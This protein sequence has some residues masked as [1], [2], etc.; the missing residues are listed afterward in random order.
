MCAASHYKKKPKRNNQY[1]WTNSMT[2]VGEITHIAKR[3]AGRLSS[4]LQFLRLSRLTETAKHEADL[5]LFLQPP[6]HQ[7]L[8]SRTGLLHTGVPLAL[9][10][11]PPAWH[12]SLARYLAQSWC[13]RCAPNSSRVYYREERL[14][15][16][17]GSAGGRHSSTITQRNKYWEWN[18]NLSHWAWGNDLKWF[19]KAM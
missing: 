3:E 7:F 12:A 19:G 16:E 13:L 1:T 11:P 6:G 15:F 2:I 4:W 18:S 9:L 10:L 14:H 8:G 17:G 5:L